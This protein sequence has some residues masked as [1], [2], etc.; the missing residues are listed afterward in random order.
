MDVVYHHDR[1]G[2]Y[3]R[4][5]PLDRDLFEFMQSFVPDGMDRN[6]PMVVGERRRLE[7]AIIWDSLCGIKVFSYPSFSDNFQRLQ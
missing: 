5:Y 3:P 2:S 7:R 6:D 1:S 4:E